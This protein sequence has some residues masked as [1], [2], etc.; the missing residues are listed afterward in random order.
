MILR[1]MPD[2][3]SC[4]FRALSTCL[5]GNTLDGMTELR[6]IVTQA[7]QSQPDVYTEAILE[8]P[9]AEYCKWI[10]NPNSWGGYVDIK[11]IAE[12]FGTEVVTIDVMSGSVTKFCEGAPMRCF[13]VY[14]GIHYDALAFVVEGA[15]FDDTEFDTK[16]FPSDDDVFLEAAQ[17][18]ARE[19]NKRGYFTDTAGFS[20]KC[21][22]CSWTGKGE[23][24][25]SKHAE[26]TGHTDFQE[27]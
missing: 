4:L 6:S 8:K 15:G 18:V 12:N 26:Q 7:I 22:Q 24:A 5:L 25:A 20:I 2:D 16:Q 23:K 19:L 3:N 21:G 10:N 14:S 17:E 27:G 11:A 1:V 9:P 13:V